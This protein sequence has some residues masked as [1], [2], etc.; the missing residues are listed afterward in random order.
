M[1]DIPIVIATKP[2]RF[3]TESVEQY[4]P[5]QN[6]MATVPN[7]LVD[8]LDVTSYYE[9]RKFVATA[10]FTID[11]EPILDALGSDY[12]SKLILSD[13]NVRNMLDADELEELTPEEEHDLA[14]ERAPCNIKFHLDEVP[15]SGSGLAGTWFLGH[16]AAS[17]GASTWLGVR[18]RSC[19]PSGVL[20][21]CDFNAAD[22]ELLA[23]FDTPSCD[24]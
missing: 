1:T 17:S 13:W 2:Q 8:F 4:E 10:P 20:T 15:L 22:D 23:Y 21:E 5:I 11:P 14:L 3:K 9:D 16:R 12:A 18:E 6:L 7:Y 19:V 24:P